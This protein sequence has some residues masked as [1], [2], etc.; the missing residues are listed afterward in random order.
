MKR[1]FTSS[2]LTELPH[3]TK[4]IVTSTSHRPVIGLINQDESWIGG[5][6]ADI[7]NCLWKFRDLDNP[8]YEIKV[9]ACKQNIE[10]KPHQ[11]R[12]LEELLNELGI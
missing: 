3:G 11:F 9:Y 7:D 12:T 6:D 10:R 8:K 5:F 4:V 1:E 2:E